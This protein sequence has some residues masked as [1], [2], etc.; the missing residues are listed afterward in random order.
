MPR[1]RKTK[2]VAGTK[3]VSVRQTRLV[4]D[5]IHVCN[6]KLFRYN[7]CSGSKSDSEQADARTVPSEMLFT[8][9]P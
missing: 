3:D 8:I 7:I 4:L 1:F 6:K 9:D 5:H 2:K